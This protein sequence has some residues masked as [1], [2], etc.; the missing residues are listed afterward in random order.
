MALSRKGQRLGA[1]WPGFVDALTAL[2]LV[3]MFVLSIFMIVQFMLRETITGQETALSALDAELSAL[4][5]ALGVERARSAA[6]ETR[7]E[8]TR[9]TADARIAALTGELE[10]AQGRI[11]SF[12]DRVAGLL[13][14]REELSA[15][16]SAEEEAVRLAAARRAALEALTEDLRRSL[17]AEGAAS[18]AL[19]ARLA[20]AEDALSEEEAA[21]LAEAAVAAAL[22]EKLSGAQ[23]ELTAMSLMLEEQRRKAEQT[24]TLLAA[25]QGEADAHQSEAERRAVLLAEAEKRLSQRQEMRIADQRKLALLNAQLADLRERLGSLQSLLDEAGI[26]EAAA[27][28]EVEKLGARLNAALAQVAAEQRARADLEEAGRKRLAEEA[29]NLE[30]YRSEFFGRLRRIF[31]GREGVRIEGDR[32]VFS[33]EVLFEPGSEELSPEG[34]AQ[35]A[36]VVGL[37]RDVADRIPPEIDWVLRVDGHTDDVAVRPG[38]RFEDNWDLS[39]AR[40][41]SVAR[42]MIGALDFPPEHLAATGFGE[43]HPVAQGDTPEARARNRRIELKLTE[44]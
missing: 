2:L 6:L 13:A 5:E 30:A 35:I 3:L 16:L 14:E 18:D 11:G 31:E 40:A 17:E 36:N 29:K 12:E 38:A 19:T 34:R 9:Q 22:R 7:L 20:A 39:Q 15:K 24:L 44:R 10:T 23:D 41:L 28:V 8:D 37:L 1:I 25:A 21:R 27:T 33:S 32:F 43:Y 4:S 26:R 42:H